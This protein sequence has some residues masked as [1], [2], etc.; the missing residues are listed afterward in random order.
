MYFTYLNIAQLEGAYLNIFSVTIYLV[1]KVILW[2]K[3]SC[4]ESYL[5][6]KVKEVEIAKEVIRSDGWWRFA[7]SGDVSFKWGLKWSESFLF[8]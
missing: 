3:L 7:S 5:V 8:S 6:M 2:W 4:D 1:M